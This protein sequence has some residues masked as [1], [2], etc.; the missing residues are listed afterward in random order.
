M[1]RRHPLVL[2]FSLSMLVIGGCSSGGASSVTEH[3]HADQLNA[4]DELDLS[5]IHLEVGDALRVRLEPSS[6][7]QAQVI[8]F[9]ATSLTSGQT[10]GLYSTD[11]ATEYISDGLDLDPNLVTQ[12]PG[13]PILSSVSLTNGCD[14]G[15]NEWLAFVALSTAVY[16]IG[17][18]RDNRTLVEDRG[19]AGHYN[20]TYST[21]SIHD[22]RIVTDEDGEA[23]ANLS[24]ERL[25]A[26]LHDH[27][28]FIMDDEFY[29]EA[30][31]EFAREGVYS[32]NSCMYEPYYGPPK[33]DQEPSDCHNSMCSVLLG[34]SP[35][36]IGQ[37]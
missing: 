14:H 2:A 1:R 9:G 28:D 11:D 33:S 32:N 20:L 34:Y 35:S 24:G 5:E 13:V 6:P 8:L 25:Y 12:F 31:F 23:L 3:A 19:F 30:M 26:A 21:E 18:T 7:L 29:P 22:S 10:A 36:R 16:Y 37:D 4:R 17:V 15:Q 27:A